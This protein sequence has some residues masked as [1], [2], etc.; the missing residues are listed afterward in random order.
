MAHELMVTAGSRFAFPYLS[1][2]D[3]VIHPER[4]RPSRAS[5]AARTLPRP[6]SS[7]C[8]ISVPGLR[9]RG[10]RPCDSRASSPWVETAQ[11]ASLSPTNFLSYGLEIRHD[12][13]L[14]GWNGPRAE[15]RVT[16]QGA[17]AHWVE[18]SGGAARPSHPLH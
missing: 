17:K 16:E 7:P 2:A 3:A 5:V 14:S 1:R 4:S 6:G 18:G 8:P 12:A 15:G 10:Q 9:H 11:P 13:N